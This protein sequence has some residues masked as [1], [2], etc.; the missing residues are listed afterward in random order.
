M[1]LIYEGKRITLNVKCKIEWSGTL[2]FVEI[3]GA[4]LYLLLGSFIVYILSD[5]LFSKQ[6]C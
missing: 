3:K 1:A 4:I 5:K 6:S 2:Q